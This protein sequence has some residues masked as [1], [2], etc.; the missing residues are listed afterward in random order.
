MP[1]GADCSYVR[2]DPPPAVMQCQQTSCDEEELFASATVSFEAVA[3]EAC[4]AAVAWL[5]GAAAVERYDVIDSRGSWVRY[6]LRWVRL[7]SA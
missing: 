7:V 5:M 3:S 4:A 1:T 6:Y 2:G